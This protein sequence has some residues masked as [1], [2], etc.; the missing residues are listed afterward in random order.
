MTP[1]WLGQSSQCSRS[2]PIV[3]T[4]TKNFDV[5]SHKAAATLARFDLD[6]HELE[7]YATVLRRTANTGALAFTGIAQKY[8]D[9]T[10]NTAR[11][12]VHKDTWELHNSIQYK[13][14]TTEFQK[15]G[16]TA[17]WEVTARHAAP[18]EYGFFHYITGKKVGPFEYVRPALAKHRKAFVKELAAQSGLNLQ[19][20]GP[21]A[22]P[23]FHTKGNR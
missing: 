9:L 10:M 18:I 11:Q 14:A 23:G 15:M 4:L 8:R 20:S 13:P 17:E 22:R 2:G 3:T 19:G 5:Y 7:D 6:V 1:I 16:F 21:N 12:L